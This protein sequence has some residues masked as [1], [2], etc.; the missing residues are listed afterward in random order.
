[1]E[2]K[3][4]RALMISNDYEFVTSNLHET[5]KRL[6]ESAAQVYNCRPVDN[7]MVTLNQQREMKN[8]VEPETHFNKTFDFGIYIPTGHLDEVDTDI[9]EAKKEAY[10]DILRENEEI[11]KVELELH[12]EEEFSNVI[13]VC[14]SYI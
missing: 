11:K 10:G 1:M 4:E 8:Y 3:F 5:A 9:M 12:K 2:L 7:K 13:N 14:I 6:F